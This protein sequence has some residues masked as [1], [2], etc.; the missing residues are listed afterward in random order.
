MNY[1]VLGNNKVWKGHVDQILKST[2]LPS[3]NTIKQIE[4]PF[5][6]HIYTNDEPKTSEAT[7]A[8]ACYPSRVRRSP[9][10]LSF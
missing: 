4:L 1:E 7:T 5:S 8:N 6:F 3:M 2:K 10:R 9:D